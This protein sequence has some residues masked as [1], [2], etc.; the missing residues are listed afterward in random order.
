MK[1]Q[2]TPCC[3]QTRTNKQ[4]KSNNPQNFGAI[5]VVQL[6]HD[7]DFNAI[8]R[9][10]EKKGC[11]LLKGA[12]VTEFFARTKQGSEAE[13]V[14]MAAI[15]SMKAQKLIDKNIQV[16]SI[17]DDEVTKNLPENHTVKYVQQ[18]KNN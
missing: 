9:Q 13:K 6:I 7:R 3:K 8:Q 5:K 10:C 11:N 1:I 18:Q 16:E 14:A 12:N 4:N 15:E 2:A 17:A